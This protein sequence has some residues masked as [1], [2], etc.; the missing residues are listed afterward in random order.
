MRYVSIGIIGSEKKVGPSQR[1]VRG[2]HRGKFEDK[3]RT[4]NTNDRFQTAVDKR[5]VSASRLLANGNPL[6]RKKI[7]KRF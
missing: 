5:R 3:L 2:Q 1:F 6:R 7:T 4:G